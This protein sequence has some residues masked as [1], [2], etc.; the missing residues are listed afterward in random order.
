MVY[1][2]TK[3]YDHYHNSLTYSLFWLIR[4]TKSKEK[5][6]FWLS[7]RNLKSRLFNKNIMSLLQKFINTVLKRVL[8]R[9]LRLF[10]R[11]YLST[12]WDKISFEFFTVSK[13]FPKKVFIYLMNFLRDK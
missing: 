5:I 4:S 1:S 13:L 3:L 12:S 9:Y 7:L 8:H 11:V 6:S 10:Y 2:L